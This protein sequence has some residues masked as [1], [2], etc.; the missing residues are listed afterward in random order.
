MRSDMELLLDILE[1]IGKIERYA[2]KG[3][4]AL[5]EDELIQTAFL[6]SSRPPVPRLRIE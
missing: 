6:M 4:D 1:A 2:S 5:F 3:K